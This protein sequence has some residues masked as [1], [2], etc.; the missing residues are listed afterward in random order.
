MSNEFSHYS[1]KII[2]FIV[3]IWYFISSNKRGSDL[4]LKKEEINVL[5]RKLNKSIENNDDYSTD[6]C[7]S[8]HDE[9]TT[10]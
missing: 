6:G 4:M 2:D 3:K 10:A 8:W 1:T 7:W 9:R 5:R